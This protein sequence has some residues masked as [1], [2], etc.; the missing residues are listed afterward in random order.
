[1]FNKIFCFY[2]SKQDII[3]S[4]TYLDKNLLRNMYLSSVPFNE[5]L[6]VYRGHV[7]YK[8]YIVTM[9]GCVDK[10]RKEARAARLFHEKQRNLSLSESTM[11]TIK[12]HYT[13]LVYVRR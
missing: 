7:S 2:C 11:G 10:S 3:F 4:C 5:Y 12:K 8:I 6:S 1:M 9:I 13:K